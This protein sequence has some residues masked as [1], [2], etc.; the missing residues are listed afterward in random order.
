MKGKNF[1][2][3]KKKVMKYRWVIYILLSTVYFL[4]N[5]HKFST[6]VMQDELIDSFN[7]ST[8]AFG[9]LSSMVFYSYLIM[10]IPSGLLADT[11]GARMTVTA[12]CIV[13]ALGS[14]L[15]AAAQNAAIANISRFVIGIGIS[16]TYISLIKIQTKWF[17]SREFATMTGLTFLLG[18]LGSVLAQTPLRM[19][20]D[21]FS[22]RSI[23]FVFG[24]MSVFMGILTFIIIRN[25]PEDM[26]LP[27]IESIEGKT[28]VIN[29]NKEK[30]KIR[31]AVGKILLN[32]YNWPTFAVVFS[33]GAILSILSGSFGSVYIRDTYGVS[34]VDA[35]RY[36]MILTLTL[37][38]GSTILGLVSDRFRKRKIFML[39]LNGT[40]TAVWVYIVV[41]SKG[42]PAFDKLK[43]LYMLTGLSLSSCL[44]SYTV[45]KESNDLTYAGLSVSFVGLMEF[46]GS[47]VGPVIVGKIIDMNPSLVGGELYSRA[48]IV[49][50]V[51]SAV[52]FA[53]TMFVK[54]TNGENITVADSIVPLQQ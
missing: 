23:Y 34:M 4:A 37:A 44:L 3:E 48:F 14:F 5:F 19:L 49:L 46:I 6:G 40:M 25:S 30:I 50:A 18:N 26:G 16:V 21:M 33:L 29:P 53:G 13:T 8:A 10:Q 42:E 39:I 51:L 20:A 1:E 17:L 54:E 24:A 2:T 41:I 28:V 15:F 22:W 9:N 32:R 43:M 35:S 12:G 47:A 27:S 11:L 38:I 31:S 52:T 7:L 45:A 36:T